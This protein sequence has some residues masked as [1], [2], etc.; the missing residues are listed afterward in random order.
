MEKI[1]FVDLHKQYLSIKDDID[2]SIQKTL[3][4][5]SFIGGNDVIQ[6]ETNFANKLK[7]ANCISV[8][9]GTDSL[10]IIQK[11]LGI[12]SGDEVITSAYS[13]IS[14]SETI[15]QTGA[16]PVF[17]DIDDYFTIDANKIE[18]AITSKT[19]ALIIVHIHGQSCDMSKILDICT[20]R[21]IFLIEDCA[22]SHLTEYDNKYVGTFG[23]AASYSFY[24][25]K[26][27]GAYGDAGAIICESNDLALK[28]KMYAR[29]GALRKH[30]H[31]IE[32]INSRLDGIQAGILNVKLEH[33]V[34][35]T[36][37]RRIVANEYYK[38]LKND[39]NIQLP[40]I[41]PNT[42]HSFHLFV[43][44]CKKRS[45]LMNYLKDNGIETAI[46]YPH[47]L[48]SLKAYEYLNLDRNKYINSIEQEDKILSLP[49]YP[50]LTPEQVKYICDKINK[51]YLI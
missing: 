28:F 20:R 2:K 45:E 49:I 47:S 5:T 42:K 35:W 8:A 40:K 32:G 44:K 48:P 41:R 37:K 9:N 4:N 16:K 1:P 12:G 50:E 10:Y 13:W 26:N 29:H 14:S 6:F 19:K 51:F 25:G 30:E 34:D 21:N 3:E 24:P 36:E 18:D 11:M 38:F 31:Q 27:L 22:Q 33:L 39:E 15:S 7:I 46:H 43:I 17:V 23:T